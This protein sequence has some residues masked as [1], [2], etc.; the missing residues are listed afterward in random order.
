MFLLQVRAAGEDDQ[1]GAG[2]AAPAHPAPGP[3][4]LAGPV[5]GGL[6]RA[7]QFPLPLTPRN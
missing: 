3:A 7:T 2:R 1:P 4:C 6:L 5:P